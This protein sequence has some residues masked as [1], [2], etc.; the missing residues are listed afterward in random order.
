MAKRKGKSKH[1]QKHWERLH[2]ER[3]DAGADAADGHRLSRRRRKLPGQEQ[4]A[5]IFA[6]L[7]SV[8]ETEGIHAGG[9]VVQLYPGG[10]LVRT[11]DYGDVMC[12]LAGTFRPA[13]GASALAVGDEVAL[14]VLPETRGEIQPGAQHID[15]D[16]VDALIRQRAPRETALSRPQ[17]MRGKRRDRYGGEIFEKVIAANMDQLVV[18]TSVAEPPPRRRLLDRYLIIA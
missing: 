5:A 18:V 6:D 11:A 3:P 13:P 10:A 15:R 7:E 8:E 4:D 17:P 1:R 14:T 12:G 2:R 16:R 9:V